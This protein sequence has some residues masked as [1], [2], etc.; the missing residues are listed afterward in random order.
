MNSS[1][2]SKEDHTYNSKLSAKPDTAKYI[3]LSLVH[4]YSLCSGFP[5]CEKKLSRCMDERRGVLNGMILLGENTEIT[6]ETGTGPSSG[7]VVNT[8]YDLTNAT[9]YLEKNWG[10]RFPYRWYWIQG[11]TFEDSKELSFVDLCVTSTG[12]LRR[13][14]FMDNR[15]QEEQVALI[16]LHWNGEFL[17][18]HKWIGRS[19]GENG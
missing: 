5:T 19:H 7:S 14:P 10:G 9:L 11:N 18:F 6:E 13:L 4:R 8:I 3:L 16:A 12:G 2:S 15:E 1:R 17:P